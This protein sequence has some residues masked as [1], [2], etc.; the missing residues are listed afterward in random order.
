M[1]IRGA[2]AIVGYHEVPTRRMYPGRSNWSLLTDLKIILWT[3][4][5]I[6]FGIGIKQIK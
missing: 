1:N 5:K 6:A 2:T 4:S 3:I